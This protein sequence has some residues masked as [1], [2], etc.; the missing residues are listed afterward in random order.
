LTV[1]AW[2]SLWESIATFLIE[3]NPNRREIEL[4][5]RLATASVFFVNQ[6]VG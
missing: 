3:W 2:V 1:A 5:D 6:K 4:C